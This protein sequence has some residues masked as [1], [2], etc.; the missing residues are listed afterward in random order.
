MKYWPTLLTPF[1][2]ALAQNRPQRSRHHS[3]VSRTSQTLNVC[4]STA[5]AL[6]NSL[7]ALFSTAVVCFQELADS[8]AKTPGVGV[9]RAAPSPLAAR[10]PRALLKTATPF[11]LACVFNNLQ[12][13][14]SSHH[15]SACLAFSNTYKS[16]FA[17]PLSFHIHTKCRGCGIRRSSWRT[18]GLGLLGALT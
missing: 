12:I 17:Q 14:R 5:C 9:P 16:L 18:P 11:R 10:S 15:R 3:L 6:L 2:A 4:A 1:L 8:F 7:V 13:P